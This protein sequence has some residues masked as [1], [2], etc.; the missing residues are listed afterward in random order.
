M[1][2]QPQCRGCTSH[3]QVISVRELPDRRALPD[4]QAA[5]RPRRVIR[6]IT[7]RVQKGSGANLGRLRRERE[8]IGSGKGVSWLVSDPAVGAV[9]AAVFVADQFLWIEDLGSRLGTFVN[10]DAISGPRR[11]FETDSVR[12]G[13]ATITFAGFLPDGRVPAGSL[14]DMPVSQ[15]EE[16]ELEERR[17][18]VIRE[19]DADAAQTLA[20]RWC[21]RLARTRLAGA[22]E[23]AGA[24]DSASELRRAARV[25]DRESATAMHALLSRLVT[26]AQKALQRAC[27]EKRRD[28]FIEP[29][30]AALH[31]LREGRDGLRASVAPYTGHPGF[32]VMIG[33]SG[34]SEPPPDDAE[35]R[36][37]HA[38]PRA[39]VVAGHAC[40]VARILDPDGGRTEAREQV[41]E[42]LDARPR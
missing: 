37:A 39:G 8:T 17:N 24:T 20:Y 7:V 35:H 10:G 3:G 31:A 26:K 6:V 15:G 30:E 41:K 9:H 27:D 21:D 22:L 14:Y 18:D 11:L 29:L 40:D 4:R 5:E 19:L 13:A 36:L 23:R 42:V 2:V 12:I 16:L 32:A 34:D 25:V 28:D 1:D 33:F 38:L